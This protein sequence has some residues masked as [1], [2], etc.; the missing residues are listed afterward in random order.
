MEYAL[1][2]AGTVENVIVA[3]PEFVA[4]ILP[5]WDHIEALDTVQELGLGVGI[6]WGWDGGAFV[7]PE[8]PAPPAIKRP[9]VYTKTEFRALLT[10]AENTLL[11]NFNF[12]EFQAEVPAIR[13]LTVMERASVR[14]AIARFK[15]G[16]DVDR[17]NPVTVR[18]ITALGALG[19]LDGPRRAETIL[20]GQAS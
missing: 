6:G 4:L 16:E 15:D 18:F 9:T 7:A 8:L 17:T 13:S 11:D 3:D 1:I 20:A 5:R 2:K 14:S 19:L 10:D 12:A